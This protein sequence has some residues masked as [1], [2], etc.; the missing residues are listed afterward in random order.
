MLDRDMGIRVLGALHA[1]STWGGGLLVDMW[2]D[3]WAAN[4]FFLLTLFW[5]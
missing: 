3:V 5:I 4:C 2:G 1:R